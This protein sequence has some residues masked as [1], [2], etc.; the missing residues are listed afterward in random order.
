MTNLD[1][2]KQML[3]SHDWFYHYSDDHSVWKQGQANISRL[4]AIA[5]ESPEHELAYKEA[6]DNVFKN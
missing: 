4:R 1:E 5:K 2:Y 6:C 3:A